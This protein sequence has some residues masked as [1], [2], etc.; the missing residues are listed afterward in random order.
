MITAILAMVFTWCLLFGRMPQPLLILTCVGLGVFLIFFSR[1]K[2]SQ[3]L[4][5]DVL[6]QNS[7]LK[8]INPMLKFWTLLSLMVICVAS[9]SVFTGVFLILAMLTLAVFVGGLSLHRYVHILALP[10]SFL[11]IGGL[12]LLFQVSSEPIGVLNFNVF[13]YWLSVTAKAQSQTA[14]IIIRALGAVSCLCVLSLTTP[15]SD[16]IGVLRRVRC[17]DIII[18]LMFLIYR[19]IFVLLSLHYEM[20]TAAKS[21]LGFIN[22]RNSV[23]STGQIYSN[24]LVRSFQYANKNFDAMESRCYDTGI[25]FLERRNKVAFVHGCICVMLLSV[26]LCLS[27]LQL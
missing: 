4:S 1:H 26:S 19:Y 11:L 6:A 23:R 14:L 24:L 3:A 22:Y 2:H 7:R 27:L 12:A 15:M 5:I 18:D 25:R 16:I 13:G 10:V 8:D 21:R 20:R 17:P 9:S